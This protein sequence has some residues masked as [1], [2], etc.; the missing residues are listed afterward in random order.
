M[1]APDL[2]VEYL[3]LKASI[4]E[5]EKLASEV[6]DKLKAE[7]LTADGARPEGGWH[8]PGADVQH[9]KASKRE[10]LSRS[11]LVKNGVTAEQIAASLDVT[12]VAETIRVVPAKGGE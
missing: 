12:P 1:S 3:S 11:K 9:V 8:F 10:S 5:L 7:L 2:A 6:R 4:E